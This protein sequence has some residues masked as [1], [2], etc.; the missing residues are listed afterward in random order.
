M[1]SR[2]KLILR[3]NNSQYKRFTE[4][5]GNE[6]KHFIAGHCIFFHFS[7]WAQD[8]IPVKLLPTEIFRTIKKTRQTLLNGDGNAAVFLIS[9]LHKA[10]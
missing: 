7:S 1:F 10:R 3:K 2:Q 5:L 9:T 6:K 4:Y 8:D